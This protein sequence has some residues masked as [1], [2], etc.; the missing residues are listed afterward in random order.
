MKKTL[1]KGL[2][3]LLF[4]FP[5][6]FPVFDSSFQ[7]QFPFAVSISFPFPASPYSSLGRQCQCSCN[8][9]MHNYQHTRSCTTCY[10]HVQHATFMYN[11]L[12]LRSYATY[13]HSCIT[14][15]RVNMHIQH[16]YHHAG[17][18]CMSYINMYCSIATRIHNIPTCDMLAW[19]DSSW[20]HCNCSSGHA[21]LDPTRDHYTHS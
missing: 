15:Q 12:K 14:C 4:P 10:V 7:L 20:D 21:Q 8:I 17:T 2:V 6:P 3:R 11:M 9:F 1:H 18:T 5:F 19:L 13:Q 16:N